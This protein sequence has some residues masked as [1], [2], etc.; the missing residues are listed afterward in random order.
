M[1][2]YIICDDIIE[3][4]LSKIEPEKLSNLQFP[5]LPEGTRTIH[6][7]LGKFNINDFISKD[8][9]FKTKYQ[10]VSY[11]REGKLFRYIGREIEYAG[12]HE[13]IFLTTEAGQ[14]K[15]EELGRTYKNRFCKTYKDYRCFLKEWEKVE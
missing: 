14:V 12:E 1:S 3:N 2:N 9:D 7:T 4:P 13:L 8:C 10:Q 5:K 11:Q 15:V 6:G